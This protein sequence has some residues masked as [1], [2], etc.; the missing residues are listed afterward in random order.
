MFKGAAGEPGAA[1][2][3]GAQGPTVS[4]FDDAKFVFCSPFFSVF[5]FFF[6]YGLILKSAFS[7][8][9]KTYSK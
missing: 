5:F 8:L 6:N 2:P 9:M 7:P 1:G 4:G 3:A